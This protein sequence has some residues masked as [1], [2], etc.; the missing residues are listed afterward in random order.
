MQINFI[1]AAAEERRRPPLG[2]TARFAW[3]QTKDRRRPLAFAALLMLIQAALG[4]AP[5]VLMRSLF[6]QALLRGNYALFAGI[7]SLQALCFIL[8]LTIGNACSGLHTRLGAEITAILRR[9]VYRHLQSL[10]FKFFV[11]TR[12]SDYLQKL[13]GDTTSVQE[14]V[15]PTLGSAL[16][17][18][19]RMA[20]SVVIMSAWDWRLAVLCGVTTPF[21]AARA[22]RAARKNRDF[23]KRQFAASSDVGNHASQS[24]GVGGYLLG[25]SSGAKEFNA[26]HFSD[27][28]RRARALSLEQ[29][30]HSQATRAAYSALSYGGSFLMQALGG[31]LVTRSD[32]TLGTLLAYGALAGSLTGPAGQLAG[33]AVALVEALSR[34]ERVRELLST[35]PE[36]GGGGILGGDVRGSLEL[37][38]LVFGYEK[39]RPVLR[40]ASLRIPAG[41]SVAVLGPSGAGKTTLAYLL[42]RLFEPDQGRLLLDGRDA[43]SYDLG[44]YRDIIGFVPQDAFFFNASVLENLTLGRGDI[45]TQDIQTACRAAQIDEAVAKLPLGLR[46]ALG[47]SGGRFSG[48]ERQRLSLARAFLRRSRIL[49]LDEPTAY[50]DK[51]TERKFLGGLRGFLGNGTT[52]VVITHRLEVAKSMDRIMVLKDGRVAEEGPHEAL[53]ASGGLYARLWSATPD[54]AAEAATS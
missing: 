16:V 19:V 28:E 49:I 15:G 8:S 2:P 14:I 25:L 4:L 27:F 52:L 46:T 40:G 43:H 10:S 24:L 41:A 6:D 38:N 36:H 17:D 35:E 33:Q 11:E 48:G 1:D 34:L 20:V 5:L 44:S 32:L 3:E 22:V 53:L 42:M 47:E 30:A 50:L 13:L 54:V 26:G 9:R 18:T 45:S 12:P 23:L 31:Y 37:E 51:E 21:L 39:T 29:A 7:L